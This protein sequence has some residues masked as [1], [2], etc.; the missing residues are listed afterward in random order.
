MATDILI[1]DGTAIVFADTTDYS[2]DLGTRTHQLDLTGIT[3][4]SA[5]QSA[6]AD[7][8]ATRA[9]QYAVVVA[10]EFGA[11]APTAGEVVKFFLSQSPSATAATANPG[12]ASGSDAAYTGTSGSS[13][14]ESVLQMTDLGV[15]TVTNDGAGTVQYE[16]IGT[17]LL[18]MRY[19]SVVAWNEAGQTF[20][21]DAAKMG[22]ALYPLK[23]QSQ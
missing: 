18:P 4:T 19:G 1:A 12:G 13:I 9:A 10:I 17:L 7:F 16:R 21:A 22:V 3:D 20:D 8:G 15:L 5:R 6:K 23:D 11:S 2:G 14:A